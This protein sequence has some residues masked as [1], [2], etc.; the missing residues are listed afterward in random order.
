MLEVLGLDPMDVD[1]ET[2]GKPAMV[3]GLLEAD[4]GVLQAGVFSDQ[5]DVD[6][7]FG[8]MDAVDQGLPLLQILLARSQAQLLEDDGVQAFAVEG[9]GHLVDVLHVHG[10]DDGFFRDVGEEADF[11][12]EIL[13]EIAV[14]PAEK[15]VR[16]DADAP[17][18]LDRML[19]GLGLE[20]AGR[21]DV[22][23]EGE[24]DEEGVL[25]T[26]GKPHLAH[27][28]QEG[29]AFDVADRAADLADDDVVVAGDGLE[30]IFDL[31]GDVGD[32]L[33]GLAQKFA[34]PLFADDGL[35]DLA[36]RPAVVLGR[37]GRSEALVMA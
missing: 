4:I 30:G 23:D 10:R 9:Q 24:V 16:L 37:P 2:M 8:M 29:Q 34:A 28:L 20:L 35:V 1:L 5:G 22:G 21:A 3:E 32:D 15:D 19:G 31:V 6:L 12:F 36:G 13:A 14:G 17:Q 33:D 7:I 18:L 26:E 11:I 27:G 25:G